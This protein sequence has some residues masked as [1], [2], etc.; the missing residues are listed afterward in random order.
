MSAAEVSPGVLSNDRIRELLA[1]S[2]ASRLEVLTLVSRPPTA[3]CAVVYQPGEPPLVVEY[4]AIVLRSGLRLDELLDRARA[5]RSTMGL[6]AALTA[7]AE[8]P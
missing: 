1:T 5:L 4:S 6:R 8:G 3:D 2:Q 7:T